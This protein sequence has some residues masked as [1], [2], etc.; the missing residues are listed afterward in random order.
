LGNAR[1]ERG[2]VDLYADDDDEN[3]VKE[4]SVLRKC[5]SRKEM[6]LWTFYDTDKAQ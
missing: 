5:Q 1:S 6:T 2:I 3:K 4:W